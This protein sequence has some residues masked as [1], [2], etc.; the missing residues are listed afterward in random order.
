MVGKL[1]ETN[2]LTENDIHRQVNALLVTKEKKRENKTNGNGNLLR[3]CKTCGE[4]LLSGKD[5]RRRRALPE[6]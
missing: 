6:T 5:L 3:H 2:E 1:A 4:K